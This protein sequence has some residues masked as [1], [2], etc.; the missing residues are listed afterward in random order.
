ML[1]LGILICALSAFPIMAIEGPR[2]VN[3]LVDLSQWQ[4]SEQTESMM[5]GEW[6]LFW[7]ELLSP[8]EVIHRLQQGVQPN[9]A[10]VPG[11][12]TEVRRGNQPRAETNIGVGTYVVK[13]EG[14]KRKEGFTYSL[15]NISV[16][17]ASRIMVVNENTST[18]TSTSGLLKIGQPGL[19]YNSTIPA[20]AAGSANYSNR[21]DLDGSLT[22][23]FFI[24][25]QISNFHHHWGGLWSPPSLF[26]SQMVEAKSKQEVKVENFLMGSIV[27]LFFVNFSL[28]L[29]RREDRSSLYLSI[30]CLITAIRY[31]VITSPLSSLNLIKDP[32][33]NYEIT[34]KIIYMSMFLASSFF[35]QFA[36]TTFDKYGRKGIVK[37]IWLV[38]LTSSTFI[39]LTRCETYSA[40]INNISKIFSLISGGY[41]CVIIFRAARKREIGALLASIGCLIL[42]LGLLA[43]I[44][45]TFDIKFVYKS[46]AS[47][48]A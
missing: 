37:I 7:G 24:I 31:F 32:W 27:V 3:G 44:L 45:R 39:L 14:L 6:M 42:T 33:L 25:I 46:I 28:F 17:T 2:A 18:S 26:T 21:L 23:S 5:E 13:V 48:I 15:T 29:Q 34:W 12:F 20:L 30:F 9:I 36:F 22:E 38:G 19:D 41:G 4:P 10:R 11:Q 40:Y 16:Y 8:R 1:R 35:A 47:L 43:E